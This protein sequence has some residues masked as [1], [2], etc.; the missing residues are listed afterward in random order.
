MGVGTSHTTLT[1]PASIDPQTT[2]IELVN[3]N[4]KPIVQIRDKREQVKTEKEWNKRQKE[5][6]F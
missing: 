3:E 1:P 6:A 4:P 5:V 2:F